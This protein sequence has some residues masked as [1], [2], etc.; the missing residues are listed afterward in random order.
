[1]MK[2]RDLLKA[3]SVG[4][5]SLVVPGRAGNATQSLPKKNHKTE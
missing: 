3:I 1:M 2:R 4:A 5:V